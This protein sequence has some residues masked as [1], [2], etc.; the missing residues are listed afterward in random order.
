MTYHSLFRKTNRVSRPVILCILLNSSPE[1]SFHTFSSFI[2][3]PYLSLPGG[4]W[5]LYVMQKDRSW[6][7]YLLILFV[8]FNDLFLQPRVCLMERFSVGVITSIMDDLR[9][10]ALP[11]RCIMV[12]RARALLSSCRH[13]K[14]GSCVFRLKHSRTC[15]L[16][17]LYRH[18][19]VTCL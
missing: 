12:Q 11:P 5:L 7:Q 14:P 16:G 9:R 6:P 13:V 2:Y 17:T 15:R 1:T 18:R 19:Q 10:S 4:Y 3:F 8:C